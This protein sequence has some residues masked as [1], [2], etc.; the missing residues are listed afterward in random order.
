MHCLCKFKKFKKIINN[1]QSLDDVTLKNKRLGSG[2]LV[3]KKKK[4]K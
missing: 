2:S 4:E 3:R 1:D